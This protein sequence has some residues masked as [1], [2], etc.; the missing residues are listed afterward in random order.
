MMTRT[1]GGIARLFF[2]LAAAALSA[3]QLPPPMEDYASTRPRDETKQ[4]PD[5]WAGDRPARS[6]QR[7]FLG[8]SF[9]LTNSHFQAL[10]IAKDMYAYLFRG[11]DGVFDA[12]LLDNG[13]MAGA[14]LL[15]RPFHLTFQSDKYRN[16]FELW[17]GLESAVYV[18]IEG[19]TMAAVRELEENT[20]TPQNI[21][22]SA[23]KGGAA[24]AGYAF[25]EM[26]F[27]VSKTLIDRRLWI[28]AAP[29][30]YIPLMYIKKTEMTLKGYSSAESGNGFMGLEGRGETNL[31]MPFSIDN[32]DAAPVLASTGV[33]MSVNALFAAARPLDIGLN[34]S[35][36]PV[37]PSKLNY[38][39]TAAYDINIKVPDIN[40]PV[41]S[42][43]TPAQIFAMQGEMSTD[44]DYT[45]EHSE[46]VN[47]NCIRPIRLDFFFRVKP[48]GTS[49]FVL[50][51]FAG[52]SFNTVL[53]P[54]TFNFG[55]A[56]ELNLPALL[57]VELGS[58]RFEDLYR[59]HIALALDFVVF[60]VDLSL[61]LEGSGF[62]ESW[63]GRGA[64]FTVAFKLGY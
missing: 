26:G 14:R 64:G 36:I 19:S 35:Q 32:F 33:D 53:S 42:G 6:F 7:E 20:N 8:V 27:A 38:R 41:W 46:R 47:D 10:Q 59:H 40:S 13:G 1:R 5:L 21:D 54:A 15:L 16:G 9:S 61:S 4:A 3:Q 63:T 25:F 55:G 62:A 37:I 50:R 60:E 48:F 57:S 18:N 22:V 44:F 51:P 17:T 29:A 39:S 2:L 30:A 31:Y 23:L 11:G 34:L 12:A 52:A 45:L 56:I 58:R 49:F 43:L 24:L 28:R